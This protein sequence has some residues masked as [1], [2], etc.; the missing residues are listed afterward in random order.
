MI[1]TAWIGAGGTQAAPASQGAPWWLAVVIGFG[2]VFLGYLLKV[3]TDW[4][5]GRR[6]ESRQFRAAALLVSDELQANIVKLEIALETEE[7]PE[8]LASDVYHRHELLLARR[9]DPETRDWVRGAYIH[10]RVHRAFQ[11][12]HKGEWQGQ[13]HVVQ[14]ALIKARKARE[15]LRLHSQGG[16]RDLMQLADCDRPF[17]GRTAAQVVSLA[18]RAY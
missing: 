10:A 8:P 5:T 7:D 4:Y 17:R 18:G 15:L 9:L 11:V 2:G 13:T 16:W 1:A 12:R 3:L 6:Q 14:E